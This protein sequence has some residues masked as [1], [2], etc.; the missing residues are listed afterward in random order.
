MVSALCVLCVVW[1]MRR[2]F[3][4]FGRCFFFFLGGGGGKNLSLYVKTVC[5]ARSFDRFDSILFLVFFLGKNLYMKTVCCARSFDRF[6]SIS[7]FFF[8]FERICI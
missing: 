7:V 3:D 6:D 2:S 4:R 8:F 1:P 5:Y